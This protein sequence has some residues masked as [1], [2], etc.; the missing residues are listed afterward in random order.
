MK[1]AMLYTGA[2]YL[3]DSGE[4]GSG[5][6]R[7]LTLDVADDILLSTYSLNNAILLEMS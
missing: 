3:L 7:I 5:E 4:T 1:A 6:D 2:W